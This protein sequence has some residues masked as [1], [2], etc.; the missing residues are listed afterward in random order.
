MKIKHAYYYKY[1]GEN[2]LEFANVKTLEQAIIKGYTLFPRP[3]Q[4]WVSI[5]GTLHFVYEYQEVKSNEL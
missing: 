1:K 2:K 5:E 4:I 3:A